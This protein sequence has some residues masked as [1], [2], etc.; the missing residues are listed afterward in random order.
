MISHFFDIDSLIRVDN[1]VWIVSKSKPSIPVVKLSQS[2]FNLIKKG[3]YKKY[4]SPLIINGTKYWLPENLFNDL[5]VKCKKHK[6]DI[7]NLSFSMQE[8]INKEVIENLDYKILDEHFHHLKNKTDDIYVICSKTNKNSYEPIINKLEQELEKRGLIV[9]NYY[10][11]SETFY[12]KNE[13][14]IAHKKVR[15]L[16]QHLIGLKTDNDKFTNEEIQKYDLIYYYDDDMKSISLAHDSN[17][18]FS[19]LLNNSSDDIKDIIRNTIKSTDN[20][21]IIRRI[22]HNKVNLFDDKEINIEFS[23]IKKT[24]ESF[25]YKF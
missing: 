10:F 24:F 13:D 1:S 4:N 8:F 19:Y 16:L 9:K 25:N 18:L 11:I 7:T 22:T 21:I 12:N 5:K 14:D 6:F 17:N 2:E 20:T 3:I 23:H 15:L